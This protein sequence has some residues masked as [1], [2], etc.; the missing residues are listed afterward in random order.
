MNGEQMLDQ[1]SRIE[2]LLGTIQDSLA[3]PEPD[4][5]AV[6]CIM[7]ELQALYDL[8]PSLPENVPAEISQIRAAFS[9]VALLH[10]SVTAAA[11]VHRDHLAAALTRLDRAASASRSYAEPLENQPI[12][13]DQRR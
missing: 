10:Q 3:Q 8:L 13:I 6:A 12:F 5:S 9:R 1:A 4:I 7:V 2:S 11:L